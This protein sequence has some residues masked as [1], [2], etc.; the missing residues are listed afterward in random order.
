MLALAAA[1]AKGV[2]LPQML[3]RCTLT[4]VR[5]RRRSRAVWL[6]CTRAAGGG[7][8]VAAARDPDALAGESSRG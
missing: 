8:L 3:A 1:E 2:P 7:A 5:G 4:S 6:V